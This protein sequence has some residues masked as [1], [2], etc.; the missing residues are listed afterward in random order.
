MT[1]S[2][3]ATMDRAFDAICIL[4]M[5]FFMLGTSDDAG[6]AHGAV[7]DL[8][9]AYDP[10]NSQ[11]L[12]LAAR[13]IGFSAAALDNLRLSMADP[14]MPDSKVLRYRSTAVSLSRSSE[15]CRATL[16]KMDTV[17][18]VVQN[19]TR[20]KRPWHAGDVRI[21]QPCEEGAHHDQAAG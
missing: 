5:P 15:Q 11:E 4:L 18:I 13:I 10:T 7:A 16:K 1:A 2:P 3:Q 8:L 20:P 21:H 9:R 12:D 17:R 6:K 19:L 14:A